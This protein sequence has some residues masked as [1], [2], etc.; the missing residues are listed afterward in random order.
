MNRI[1]KAML[2]TIEI[3]S[4]KRYILLSATVLCLLL[5]KAINGFWVG[6]FWLHSA[7]IR[8]F[9]LYPFSPTN[10]F[11]PL[12]TQHFYHGPYHWMVGVFARVFGLSS[13]TALGCMGLLNFIIF[14]YSLHLFCH[15][16]N[17]A[18]HTAFYALVFSLVLWG[19]HPWLYSSFF[20]LQTIGFCFPYPSFFCI[21]LALLS[22]ALFIKT[23]QRNKK[24]LFLSIIPL[25][26]IV[27][28]SHTSTSIVLF[29]GLGIILISNS[30]L[31]TVVRNSIKLTV[32][33]LCTL[34]LVYLWPHL[35]LFALLSQKTNFVSHYILDDLTLYRDVLAKIWPTLFAV[36]FIIIRLYKNPK[37]TLGLLF[38]G[39]SA[40][41]FWGYLTQQWSYG[42]S[43]AQTILIAH[44]IFADWF[45]SLK[46]RRDIPQDIRYAIAAC[47][48]ILLF[49]SMRNLPVSF[50]S[51]YR[52]Q[53][54]PEYSTLNFIAELTHRENIVLTDRYSGILV[55]SFGGKVVAYDLIYKGQEPFVPD[56]MD[57][58]K[59]ME[60]FFDE[61]TSAF[62]REQILT[63]Y[64][65]D[66]VLINKNIMPP[67]P[68]LIHFL[69]DT[70]NLEYDCNEYILFSI[71]MGK[72]KS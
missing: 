51:Q 66:F 10:P 19:E 14:L 49:V 58:I 61:K 67:F 62:D 30:S 41:Y 33:V 55:P 54:I 28:L 46:N 35:S 63:K 8:E 48:I 50:W 24:F 31:L 16:L 6:D 29:A 22:F 21:G 18:R 27:M 9:S 40:V 64:N 1:R 5:I 23:L 37:D 11:L 39:F 2:S 47:M 26:A 44:I 60:H 36:P 12:E 20:H 15:T 70:G 53:K 7:V 56:G 45:A 68:T 43:I 3:I 57:R 13:I 4:G 65:V 71:N 59:D 38:L 17:T 69:E 34:G 72:T 25:S 52:I 32:I 42:R